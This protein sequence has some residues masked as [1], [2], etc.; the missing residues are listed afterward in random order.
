MDW[1]FVW[2]TDPDLSELA[3]PWIAIGSLLTLKRWI[4]IANNC[5]T[6]SRASWNIK[7]SSWIKHW[8]LHFL[9]GS[10]ESWLHIGTIIV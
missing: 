6:G 10:S 2:D 1:T 4:H 3:I 8:N 7:L 5:L 9:T